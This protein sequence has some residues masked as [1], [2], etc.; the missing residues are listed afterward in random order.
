MTASHKLM[1]CVNAAASS[2]Y[3]KILE[4]KHL[5]EIILE[6]IGTVETQVLTNTINRDEMFNAIRKARNA[7][8]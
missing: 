3:Q 8:Q 2:N 4:I 1:H 7:I 6:V 5:K